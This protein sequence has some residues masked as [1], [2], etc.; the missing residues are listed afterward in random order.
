MAQHVVKNN[1]RY[2]KVTGKKPKWT[3][4]VVARVIRIVTQLDF[5]RDTKSHGEV[6]HMD[7]NWH[8]KSQ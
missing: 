8:G 7:L 1:T 3:L 6:A 2:Y 4:R 5:K